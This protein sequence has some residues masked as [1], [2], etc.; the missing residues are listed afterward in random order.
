MEKAAAASPARCALA[1]S[2]PG[3]QDAAPR[4]PA[5]LAGAFVAVLRNAAAFPKPFA[6]AI[7]S[8][9]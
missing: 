7:N 1:P 5:S 3:V 8:C 4:T 9:F 2:P 6:R